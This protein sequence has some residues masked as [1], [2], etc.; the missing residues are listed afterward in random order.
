M[1][2]DFG[3]WNVMKKGLNTPS[4]DAKYMKQIIDYAKAKCI[5]YG[6][7][8]DYN[9]NL[10]SKCS[11]SN[12]IWRKLDELHERQI[13]NQHPLCLM[14]IEEPKVTSNS[15]DSNSYAFDELQDAYNEL[16]VE[17][18]SMKRKY[19]KMISKMNVEN[20]FLMNAKNVL[21]KK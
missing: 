6:A 8:D 11:T 16:Y 21:E 14:A 3:V 12:E 19:K 10:V 18:E 15:I 13:S 5:L 20:E 2:Q 9:F 1:A 17:C 7:L 4:K